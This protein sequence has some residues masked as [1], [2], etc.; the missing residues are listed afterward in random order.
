MEVNY[1]QKAESIPGDGKR[2]LQGSDG[3][4]LWDFYIRLDFE[5][6]APERS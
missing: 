4:A 3:V 5:R 1:V 6:M 2:E